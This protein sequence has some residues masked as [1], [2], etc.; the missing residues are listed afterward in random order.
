MKHGKHRANAPKTPEVMLGR[1]VIR[2]SAAS[3][4]LGPPLYATLLEEAKRQVK[5]AQDEVSKGS[6][7]D[8]ELG[9]MLGGMMAG[10]GSHARAP[11]S[12]AAY[13]AY[14]RGERAS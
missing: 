14:R 4:E 8:A 11:E 3:L 9:A 5:K 6:S 12:E 1:R 7:G 10:S 13:Q 2:H